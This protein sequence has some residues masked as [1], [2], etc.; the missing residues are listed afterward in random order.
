MQT[1]GEFEV[2][3]NNKPLVWE[4]KTAR[5]L[6]AY[7][8]DK[9]GAAATTAEIALTLWDD[10]SKIRSV[11]TIISS[12]RKTLKKA[13]VTDVLVKSRNRTAVD[14][15]KICCDLYEFIDGKQSM[16]IEVNICPITAGLNLPMGI[17]ITRPFTGLKIVDRRYWA[18]RKR[19]SKLVDGM[20]L[21]DTTAF[22]II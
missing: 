5:E 2:F 18:C 9:R 3:V 19:L 8:V 16:L 7:L 6:M 4:R 21:S 10:D 22:F 11:Q 1:F 20:R 17:C 14:V 13:G 12:L 15:S